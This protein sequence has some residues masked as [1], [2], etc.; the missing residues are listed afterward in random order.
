MTLDVSS[1]TA[2]RRLRDV[3]G[4]FATGVTVVTALDEAGDPVGITVNSFTSVSLSPPLILWCLSR[5]SASLNA[6]CT[7]RHFA[8][9]VLHESQQD[10]ATRFASN[11]RHKF[12]GLEGVTEGI[13]GVPL[14]AN[15]VGQLQCT[16]RQS[17][18]GGDHVILI[19]EVLAVQEAAG[20]P[21][22]FHR[23]RFAGLAQAEDA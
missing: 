13:S 19:G 5:E 3:L 1:D 18:D 8:I 22:L 6:Y 21:L 10:L 17:H 2:R 4:T 9:N 20:A 16:S 7:A 15:C 23:G 14:L 12:A 11:E